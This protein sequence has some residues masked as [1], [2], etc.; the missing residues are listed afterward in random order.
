[1][2][3]QRTDEHRPSMADPADYDFICAFY[4]GDSIWLQRAYAAEMEIYD[5]VIGTE[6]IWQ[7]NWLF[8]ST[9]DHCGAAFN[10]GVLFKHTPTEELVHVGHICA[11][12]TIGLPDRAAVARAKAE[13]VAKELEFKAER[14]EAAAEWRAENAPIVVWLNGPAGDS[15][16]FLRDM[17]KSLA[18][19]GKLTDG[20]LRAVVNWKRRADE[21]AAESKREITAGPIEAGRYSMTGTVLNVKWQ[22]GDFGTQLKML[23][24]LDGGNRVWGT[25]PAAISHHL[26]EDEIKGRKV[27]FTATVKPKAG[28]PHFGYF[29]RPAGASVVG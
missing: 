24:E 11:A 5:S 12:N 3:E 23:V 6:E 22:E 18:E 21:R 10:H 7:G 27:N 19:W 8:K 28:D 9:C 25:C 20:Q 2:A 17:K 29:S 13:R 26:P 1:V 14:V 16:D 15:H 4:Q